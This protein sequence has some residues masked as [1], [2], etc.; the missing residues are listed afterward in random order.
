MSDHNLTSVFISPLTNG[1]KTESVSPSGG[2]D[3]VLLDTDYSEDLNLLMSEVNI[4]SILIANDRAHFNLRFVD[5]R[6]EKYIV[7]YV[8]SAYEAL[9]T[10]CEPMKTVTAEGSCFVRLN[11]TW[12]LVYA[13]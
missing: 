9:S 3:R 7:S 12:S 2:Y 5:Y 4:E 8:R 6:G 1:V 11:E 10:D 13:W